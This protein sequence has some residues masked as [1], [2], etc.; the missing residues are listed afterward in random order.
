MIGIG[1][2]KRQTKEREEMGSEESIISSISTAQT[3]DTIGLIVLA[4]V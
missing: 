1:A 3:S 4:I 2:G